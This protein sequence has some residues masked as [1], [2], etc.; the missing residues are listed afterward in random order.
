MPQPSAPNAV[1]I[2]RPSE[3]SRRL[4]A[5]R[6]A[7]RNKLWPDA[8]RVVWSRHDA[9]GFT[10]IPRTLPLIM[11]LIA[12]LTPK[13]DASRVY[14]DL[15]FRAFD[16]GL[17]T[18]H[19][20]IEMAYACGYDGPRAARTWREHIQ[21]L[22]DLGFIRVKQLGNREV[23]HVLLL[24][25]LTAAARLHT[26]GHVSEAWWNSFVTR[27]DEIGAEIPVLPRHPGNAESAL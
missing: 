27:A 20:E 5:R 15:W 19:D 22:A 3:R 21:T 25:P 23:G 10:T 8:T 24:D 6:L 9:K 4:S 17:V 12:D 11:R 16:E 14:L 26:K 18:V 13:G 1:P 7:L 2:A